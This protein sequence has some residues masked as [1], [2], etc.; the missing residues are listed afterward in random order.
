MSE[1][2]HA[3]KNIKTSRALT[4]LIFYSLQQIFLHKYS[5]HF[6]VCKTVT[7]TGTEDF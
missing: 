2:L 3:I 7:F 5:N 6:L 1:A 4:Q